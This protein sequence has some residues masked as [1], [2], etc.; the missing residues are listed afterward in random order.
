MQK[1]NGYVSRK[2]LAQAGK[3]CAVLG[4]FAVSCGAHAALPTE[5]TAAL[6]SVGTGLED[7]VSAVWPY[8]GTGIVATLTIKLVKK[9]SNKIG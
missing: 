5:A 9:F 6:T 2:W 1:V 4:S 7:V 8:I 3:A